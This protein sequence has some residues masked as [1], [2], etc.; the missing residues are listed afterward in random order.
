MASDPANHLE[1]RLLARFSGEST[2]TQRA[3]RPQRSQRENIGFLHFAIFAHLCAFALQ[4]FDARP[5]KK[6]GMLVWVAGTALLPFITSLALAQQR[7]RTLPSPDVPLK[8]APPASQLRP[9]L[10]P[11]LGIDGPETL[12][13]GRT[14]PLDSNAPEIALDESPLL[15]ELFDDSLLAPPQKLSPYKDSFFQKLSLGAAWMGNSSDP[16]DLGLTEVET[17]AQ[18]GLPA[19]IIEWPLLV[20]AG[21]N[22]TLIDGP[23][24][25]DL[26]PR[27]YL[28]SVDLM[29]LPQIVRGYTLLISVVPSVFGDFE[30]EQ[31]RLTG[32]GLLIV[33]LLPERLQFVGG[34]LYLN[35][36]NIR[37]LPAGGLIW[38]PA[39]WTR[40]ELI[41]PK[42]KLAVRFNV[43]LGYEDWLFTTAEFGGN[44]WPIIRG[45]SVP[46]SEVQDNVTYND[47][48]LL[49]GFERKLQGGAGYRLEAGYVFGRTITFTSGRGDFDPQDTFLL[50]G[51]IIY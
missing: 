49:V 1:P 2:Q 25:T 4:R 16:Q 32:K 39:P 31:F 20:T 45:G 17:F 12:P 35:R 44:T 9:Y 6:I 21:F 22:L 37:L 7:P 15:D 41:F 11:P 13:P 19:P 28:A 42:P 50:R 51:G 5:R 18:V 10:G 23:T 26:P 43:G 40:F 38:S 27:L 30:A 48:R 47:Y 8:L 3:R 36:D 33:D 14:S 24:V 46:G 29:W 34:L